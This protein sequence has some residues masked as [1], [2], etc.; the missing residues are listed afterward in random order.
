MGATP[1]PV[2]PAP[3][4]QRGKST[5][6]LS[7]RLEVRILPGALPLGTGLMRLA[8]DRDLANPRCGSWRAGRWPSYA[9]PPTDASA[10]F[11]QRR[12]FRSRRYPSQAIALTPDPA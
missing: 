2:T 1:A 11:P 9:R 8:T 7:R 4:A 6:L 10:A 3:V 12:R 5:G